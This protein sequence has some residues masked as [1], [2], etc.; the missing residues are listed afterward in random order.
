MRTKKLR[1]SLQNGYGKI[2]DPFYYHGDME[3]IRAYYDFRRKKG[4]DSFL[5][6]EITWNDLDMDALFKRINPSLTTSGEQ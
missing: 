2:P 3:Y 6:D 5:L 4:L 1:K